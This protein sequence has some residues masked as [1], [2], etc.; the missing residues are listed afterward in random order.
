[1]QQKIVEGR[2]MANAWI[3]EGWT[4]KQVW[5]EKVLLESR[6]AKGQL[7]ERLYGETPCFLMEKEDEPT[8]PAAVAAGLPR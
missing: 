7:S 8:E 1:M 2:Y 6:H 4:V 3:A 5:T